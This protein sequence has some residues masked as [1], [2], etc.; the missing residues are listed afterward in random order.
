MS[1]ANCPVLLSHTIDRLLLPKKY[2][3]WGTRRARL[4]FNLEIVQEVTIP[5][6]LAKTDP[7]GRHV[8]EAIFCQVNTGKTKP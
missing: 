2:H 4:R 3:L 6:N 7:V 5:W 1:W 8:V